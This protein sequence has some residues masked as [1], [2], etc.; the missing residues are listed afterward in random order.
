MKEYKQHGFDGPSGVYYDAK[1]DELFVIQK[2][3]PM[4]RWVVLKKGKFK[5]VLHGWT[6]VLE[7]NEG[8]SSNTALQGMDYCFKVGEL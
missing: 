5:G 7:T 4:K 6:Y 1:H 3:Y 2:Q 8:K